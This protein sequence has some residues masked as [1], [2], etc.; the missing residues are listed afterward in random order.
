MAREF[1]LPSKYRELT[2]Y[3]PCALVACFTIALASASQAA[4]LLV[5][6]YLQNFSPHSII[7]MW[8]T[9]SEVE[10]HLEALEKR[11]LSE[12][13]S[14]RRGDSNEHITKVTIRSA[15][16]S[17]PPGIPLA[18]ATEGVSVPR[19]WDQGCFR[20]FLSHVAGVK[21]LALEL[22]V[23]LREYHVSAFVAHEDIQPTKELILPRF[24]GQIVK[25]HR[26]RM[27]PG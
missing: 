17:A 12:V 20:L 23:S 16:E 25:P 10:G 6:P 21:K 9:D 4:D 18:E 11:L 3:R 15:P 22:K 24:S 14:L 26:P 5:G 1:R 19:H 7:V 8:E 27:Q 2:M 13:K